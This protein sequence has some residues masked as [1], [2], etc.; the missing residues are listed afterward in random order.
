MESQRYGLVLAWLL[1]VALGIF[2]VPVTA[3]YSPGSGAPLQ[4]ADNFTPPD[5][6]IYT[7]SE[8]SELPSG[9]AGPILMIVNSTSAGQ[10]LY[11]VPAP[12]D[13]SPGSGDPLQRRGNLT[14]PDLNMYPV[15]EMADDP[16]D[17]ADIFPV[18]ESAMSRTIFDGAPVSGESDSISPATPFTLT[19]GRTT[20]TAL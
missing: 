13:N 16:P 1:I 9:Y 7:L 12:T 4:M 14:P 18:P 5:P 2:S 11:T 3:D 8:L 20:S 10:T 15:R 6:A 19:R 17:L